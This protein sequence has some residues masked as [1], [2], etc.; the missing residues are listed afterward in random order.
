M[1]HLIPSLLFFRTRKWKLFPQNL[2]DVSSNLSAPVE[3]KS[4]FGNVD[5]VNHSVQMTL[6]YKCSFVLKFDWVDFHLHDIFVFIPIWA[7]HNSLALGIL[8][9]SVGCKNFYFT[10]GHFSCVLWIVKFLLVNNQITILWFTWFP[11]LWCK[12]FHASAVQCTAVGDLFLIL[13][14]S[15][16]FVNFLFNITFTFSWLDFINFAT[17]VE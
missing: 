11:M 7:L 9:G 12:N 10:W 8:K 17:I 3:T 4:L 5:K 2:L 6:N 1:W 15:D 13:C 14:T 16:S